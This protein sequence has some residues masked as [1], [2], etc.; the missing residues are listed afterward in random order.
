MKI[1]SLKEYDM[2]LEIKYLRTDKVKFLE[3]NL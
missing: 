3:N 1:M 2:S